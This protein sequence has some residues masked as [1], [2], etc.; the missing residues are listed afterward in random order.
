[1]ETDEGEES[2]ADTKHGADIGFQ[3]EESNSGSEDDEDID[4]DDADE[5]YDDSNYDDDNDDE[6]NKNERTNE[7]TNHI[8]YVFLL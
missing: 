7:P 6:E 3:A 4:Y 1:M 2:A 8:K 5:D